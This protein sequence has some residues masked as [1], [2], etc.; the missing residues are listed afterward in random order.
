MGKRKSGLEVTALTPP[1]YTSPIG[2]NAYNIP[3]EYE[4]I[5]LDIYTRYT[6]EKPDIHLSDITKLLV[7]EIGIPENLVPKG[8]GLTSWL[9]PGTDILDFEK[10]LYKGY[11][12]LLL[13]E[14]IDEVDMIWEDL[15]ITLDPKIIEKGDL[16]S[17]RLY[18]THINKL[19]SVGKI[20]ANSIGMLQTGGGGKVYVDFIDFFKLLGRIGAFS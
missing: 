4:A 13:R 5:L 16:R 1:F 3:E 7:D 8:D 17:K 10:W 20:D 11:F 14:H 2:S 12:Y 15:W 19:I 6:E 18:L 9:I